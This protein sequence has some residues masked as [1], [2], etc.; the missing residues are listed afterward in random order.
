MLPCST[1]AGQDGLWGIPCTSLRAILFFGP[2]TLNLLNLCLSIA[3]R[4]CQEPSAIVDLMK[5]SDMM[6]QVEMIAKRGGKDSENLAGH[7]ARDCEMDEGERLR[8]ECDS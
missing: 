5:T 4:S 8:F 1:G 2:V 6:R 3:L 7:D